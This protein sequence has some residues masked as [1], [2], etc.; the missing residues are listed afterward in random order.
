[1]EHIIQ[2]HTLEEPEAHRGEV[3]LHCL[4]CGDWVST[5]DDDEIIAEFRESPC[6]GQRQHE[7]ELEEKEISDPDGP[8]FGP[9]FQVYKEDTTE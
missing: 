8:V 6:P 9:S 2:E 1:M 7:E 3:V 4:S 5:L